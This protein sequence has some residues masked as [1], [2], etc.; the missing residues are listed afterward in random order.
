MDIKKAR[1]MKVLI[2]GFG[3][4]GKER[5]KSLKK[6]KLADSEDIEVFDPY[7]HTNKSSEPKFNQKD[8]D[9]SEVKFIEG[10]EIRNEY[11]FIIFSAPHK[12]NF[13]LI[14]K[15][16]DNSNQFLLEK[17]MGLSFQEA[18]EIFKIN[19]KSRTINIGFNYRFFEPIDALLKDLNEEKF[20][21]LININ[22]KLGHGHQPN[23]ES[24]WR[25]DKNQIPY[26]ALIDPGI[27]C[28][29][30]INYL[31]NDIQDINCR[32]VSNFWKK[33]YP[34]DIYFIGK[35]KDESN[36]ICNVS[37]VSW[38]STFYIH[39]LG[40]EGYGYIEGRGRTYGTQVYKTG[41][42]WDWTNG[43][44]Q[45]DNEIEVISSDCEKSF[46]KEIEDIIINKENIAATAEDGLKAMDLMERIYKS[47]D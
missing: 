41:K 23:A 21:K 17:P 9:L 22:M 32:F 19:S 47:I 26:G 39:V 6:L 42:R 37:N 27:H 11:D 35:S 33:G 29:D 45:K 8:F 38:K 25:L 4:I 30:L 12:E 13:S 40:T 14:N 2:F 16:K 3:L 5:Y 24:S 28:I 36:L 34:E 31:F 46:T 43:K 10:K 20:G 1:R 7:V 44:T 18:N 15:Y